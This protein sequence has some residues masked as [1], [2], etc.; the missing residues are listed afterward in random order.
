MKT[1]GIWIKGG[2]KEQTY[3]TKVSGRIS[4]SDWTVG[5]TELF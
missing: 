1:G 2:R 5:E 3:K 4:F